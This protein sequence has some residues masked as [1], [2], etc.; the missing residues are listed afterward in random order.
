MA[1]KSEPSSCKT[2]LATSIAKSLLE[3]VTQGVKE[4]EKPPRLTGFL[5]S[6]DEASKT[7]AE[8]TGKSAREQYVKIVESL[9]SG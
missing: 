4:L 2:I 9:E 5:A 8:W 3:E 7:Y 1:S 6:G